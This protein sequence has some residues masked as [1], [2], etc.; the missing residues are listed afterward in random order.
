VHLQT[1]A[2]LSWLLGESRP[3]ERGERRLVLLAGLIPDLDAVTI[4]GGPEIYERWHRMILHNGLSAVVYTGLAAALAT[5][6]RLT[7]AVLSLVSM[8]L[9]FLCDAIGAAG[10]D[11]S[12]WPV[13]YFMPFDATPYV[14][15]GQ[16]GLASWQNVTITIVA[17]LA[18]IHLGATR[19]RTLI[20]AFSLRADARVVASL[21][22][23]WP[24]GK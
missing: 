5:K 17:M 16:W 3:L 1:H 22:N 20:E 24:F 23:L 6:N 21:R 10:P 15:S 4:L 2:L 14:W 11:G 9:H 19:G 8:H 18:C 7:T 12:L 13:P